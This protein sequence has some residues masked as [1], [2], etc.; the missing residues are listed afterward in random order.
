MS[1]LFQP[2]P[3]QTRPLP[4]DNAE[5]VFELKYDGLRAI[6]A[7]EHGR[8]NLISR[9]GHAFAWGDNPQWNLAPGV[10]ED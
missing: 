6:A 1:L 9:N 8:C 4:F 5:Y 7:V 2:M 10:L 3:L